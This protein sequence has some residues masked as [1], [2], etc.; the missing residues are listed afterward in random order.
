MG[1]YYPNQSIESHY[2]GPTNHRGARIVVRTSGGKRLVVPYD[3][4]L[5]PADNHVE[6]MKAL[7]IRLGWLGT[8]GFGI[9]GGTQKGF[10]M[11]FYSSGSIVR[12]PVS[13]WDLAP[14]RIKTNPSNWTQSQ[15]SKDE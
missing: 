12:S 6:A 8:T 11:T 1:K 4:A 15:G 14:S 9:V 10:C 2:V 5:N 7:A 3:H 13:E